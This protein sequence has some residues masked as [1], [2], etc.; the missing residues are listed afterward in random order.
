[1]NQ[2]HL[3]PRALTD[4]DAIA[5]YSLAEWGEVQTR[6]YLADLEA[7]FQ[8]LADNPMLGK[9]RDEVAMGYRSYPERRHVIFYLI[10]DESIDIIGIPHRS[11]DI[12]TY[13]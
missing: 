2:F 6:R 9:A 7:R 4:I 10:I 5:D 13:F 12:D 3:T 1:M 8:W 11:R